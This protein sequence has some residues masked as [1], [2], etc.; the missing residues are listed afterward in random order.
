MLEEIA[1]SQFLSVAGAVRAFGKQRLGA[2]CPL[3]RHLPPS[4]S[5]YWGPVCLLSGRGFCKQIRGENGSGY[6]CCNPCLN[7]GSAKPHSY[8]SRLLLMLKHCSTRTRLKGNGPG[9]YPMWVETAVTQT[10]V[11][12]GCPEVQ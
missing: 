4:T 8:S 11:A 1:R 7:C 9:I 5:G 3:A 12:P 2:G 10:P 6:L